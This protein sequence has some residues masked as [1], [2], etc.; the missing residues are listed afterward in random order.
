[1]TTPAQ[2]PKSTD[3]PQDSGVGMPGSS[4]KTVGATPQEGV[5]TSFE[6]EEDPEAT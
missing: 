2:E 6:P 4:G 3:E 1:M 5:D